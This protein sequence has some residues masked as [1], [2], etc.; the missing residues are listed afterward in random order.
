MCD[1]LLMMPVW[2]K[3]S[4]KCTRLVEKLYSKHFTSVV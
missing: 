1:K 3:I 2:L 4:G